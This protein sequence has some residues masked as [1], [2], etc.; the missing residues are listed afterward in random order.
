MAQIT[1]FT[2][3]IRYDTTRCTSLLLTHVIEKEMATGGTL[4]RPS[5]SNY[6]LSGRYIERSVIES[7]QRVNHLT[8]RHVQTAHDYVA[9]A[10]LVF[11]VCEVRP[12][13]DESTAGHVVPP[14][15]YE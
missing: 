15:L 12:V 3:T 5:P 1:I 11:F 4:F 9:N 10:E 6:S 8:G 14:L 7:A 13:V 2:T